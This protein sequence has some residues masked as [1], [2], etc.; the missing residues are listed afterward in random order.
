MT[1][2]ASSIH[3]VAAG[4]SHAAL[5]AELH[6]ESFDEGWSAAS[7]ETTLG[8]PGSYGFIAVRADGAGGDNA[9]DDEPLGFALLR[10]AGGEA[11]VITIATRPRA[12]GHGVAT[13]LMNVGVQQARDL[14]ADAM[15]LEVA[16][17]NTPAIGLY[18]RLG[19]RNVGVRPK[20]YERANT[21]RIDAI[22]MKL[23]LS[24]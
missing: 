13:R 10:A 1:D 20:Y 21:G 5:L 17:D 11:E 18:H 12:R 9:G 15:F 24:A 3:L 23:D 22:V 7:I 14:G 4:R 16:A 6:G 8:M 19:F 2:R